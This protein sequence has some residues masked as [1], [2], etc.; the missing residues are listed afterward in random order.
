MS[1]S[2]Q[3]ATELFCISIRSAIY[4][5]NIKYISSWKVP[6]H[7]NFFFFLEFVNK[8]KKVLISFTAGNFNYTGAREIDIIQRCLKWQDFIRHEFLNMWLFGV[9][10]D[11]LCYAKR[12]TGRINGKCPC[13]GWWMP[14]MWSWRW[15]M[16]PMQMNFTL[17]YITLCW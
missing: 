7:L 8:C 2:R 6:L 16:G 11:L 12:C 10:C 1:I 3:S 17:K 4:R 5:T 15:Q 9:G 14:R 13:E